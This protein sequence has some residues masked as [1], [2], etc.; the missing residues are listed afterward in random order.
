MT[1]INSIIWFGDG[2][3][4]NKLA[5][6]LNRKTDELLYICLQING[7]ISIQIQLPIAQISVQKELL[8]GYPQS[9]APQKS[10]VHHV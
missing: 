9:M 2:R 4:K 3:N 7:D 8:W 5:K 6:Y 10:K 1:A